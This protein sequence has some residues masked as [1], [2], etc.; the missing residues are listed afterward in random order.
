MSQRIRRVRR[1]PLVAGLLA[2]A[3]AVAVAAVLATT[4]GGA[5]AAKSTIKVAILSDCEGAFGS[6]YEQD[7]GG[8]Q[9]ALAHW[10]H[11]KPKN[12]NKPSAGMTGINVAGHPIKIVGYG[13]SNDRADTAIKE[14]R[15][16]MEQNDAD[17][18][19]G[20]LS[21]DES[22]AVSHY[23]K[24]HPKKT[25]INGAAGA[26]DTTLKTRAKNYFRFN[27]DGAQFTAGNGE[28]AYRKLKWRKVAVISDDYSFAWTNSG[29]FIAE[30]CALGGKITKRVYPPLNT[31]D[32]SSYAQQLPSPNQ[33]DGYFW[34]VG[35][36]GLIPSLK[37]Y[38]N[39]KGRIN[40]KKFFGNVFWGTPGQFQ[41]LGNRVAGA[42]AGQGQAPDL[43]T[44]AAIRYSNII[45]SVYKQ[46]PPFGAA[47]PQAGSV[48][49]YTYFVAA[50][51]LAKAL[52]KVKGDISGGQKKLQAALAKT[53]LT[54]AAYGKI[55][56]DK[57]R[58]A[59]TDAYI[60]QLYVKGGK[61]AIKTVYKTPNTSQGFGGI[62]TSKTPSPG[63]SFPKCVKRK[64]PPWVGHLIKVVNGIPR[65]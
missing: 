40:G 46:F 47:K 2:L 30:F 25:F 31:T 33:V 10:A 15:R 62:F 11:G 17:I 3:G 12:R 45:G 55:R 44:K 24:G 38:Q 34:A 48:F 58:N 49:T 4:A 7:I 36:S 51:A 14:T 9:A 22:V 64:P 29:G 8:A 42:H 53:V 20:P 37:A 35:G 26:Q 21:G 65:K 56:L 61:L 60:Q 16:L 6:F 5:G 28:L 57:N 41:Q 19:I 54:D 32:Y 27:L 52:Q 59:I 43:K 50:E 18:L 23:A 63:R 1:L 39:A 13:C